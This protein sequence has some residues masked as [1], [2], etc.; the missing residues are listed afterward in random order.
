MIR[1]RIGPIELIC[2]ASRLARDLKV[3][4]AVSVR[5][6]RPPRRMSARDA[7]FLYLERS[8]TQLHMGLAADADLVPDLEKLER[9][10]EEAFAA[11]L[12]SASGARV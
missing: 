10:L 8:H 7:G 1:A 6:P 2:V 11:L 9:S 5:I 4:T 12:A 3:E